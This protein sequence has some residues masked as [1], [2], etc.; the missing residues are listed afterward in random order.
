MRHGSGTAF[1][2]TEILVAVMIFSVISAAMLAV[3]NASTLLFQAGQRARSAG[4]EAQAILSRFNGDCATAITP[5]GGGYFYARVDGAGDCT[6]GWTIRRD[7]GADLHDG[8]SS[9]A[10]PIAF[11]VWGTDGDGRLLRRELDVDHQGRPGLIVLNAGQEEFDHMGRNSPRGALT[12]TGSDVLTPAAEV[13]SDN[14]HHFGIWLVGTSIHT[15]AGVDESLS[16]VEGTGWAL[17]ERYGGG[18]A[19]AEPSGATGPDALAYYSDLEE[20]STGHVPYY[21]SA[22]HI[23]LILGGADESAQEGRLVDIDSSSVQVRGLRGF[24]AE[25]GGL[26]KVGG[27]WIGIHRAEGDRLIINQDWEDGPLG[28]EPDG[29]PGTGRGA[30]RSRQGTHPVGTVV[31]S[32][33]LYTLTRQLRL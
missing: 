20:W 15:S 13:M 22:I 24:V 17:T 33:R 8:L 1:T 28:V 7:I 3:F 16:P 29:T 23:S 26:I 14:C 32:G 12:R 11:V 9:E 19:P 21:P 2:L 31:R 27:E 5:S 10:H 6:V 4:D 18:A 30:L 25:P